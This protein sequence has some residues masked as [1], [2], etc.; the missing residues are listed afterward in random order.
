MAFIRFRP[1]ISLHPW[2]TKHL[3]QISASSAHVLQDI[4]MNVHDELCTIILV[5]FICIAS[6]PGFN[7]L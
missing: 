7:E 5:D 6:S 2:K 1:K 3:L 4:A